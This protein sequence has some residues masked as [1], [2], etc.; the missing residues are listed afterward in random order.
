[1][2][3]LFAVLD[4]H[5]IDTFDC[6]RAGVTHCDCLERARKKVESM[7]PNAAAH[8]GDGKEP[9]MKRLVRVFV[10]LHCI[11][12]CGDAVYRVWDNSDAAE[13][14]AAELQKS[15]RAPGITFSV[16]E[17]EIKYA[18]APREARRDSGVALHAVVG[19]SES[20]AE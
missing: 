15:N 1:M 20:G 14:D 16:E 5:E 8:G 13:A 3:E 18:N 19:H 9:T 4:A 2:R 17:H 10:V 11:E 12:Y 6:D 7:M